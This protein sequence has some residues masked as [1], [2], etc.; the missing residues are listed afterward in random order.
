MKMIS[1]LCLFAC[2][3]L[4]SCQKGDYACDC[5]IIDLTVSPPDTTQRTFMFNDL[6]ESSASESCSVRENEL[7]TGNQ[8]DASCTLRAL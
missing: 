8:A 6:R 7:G 5:T 1:A 3:S 2:L 4:V